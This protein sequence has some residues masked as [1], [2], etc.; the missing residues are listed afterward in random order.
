MKK[1]LLTGAALVAVAAGALAQGSFNLIANGST[2]PNNGLFAD[3]NY[4]A[5]TYGV[6]VYMLNATTGYAPINTTAKTSGLDA[7]AMLGAAGYKLEATFANQSI[8]AANA[9]WMNVGQVNMAD[10]NP[11][12]SSVVVALAA[13]N[14]SAASW[15]AAMAAGG[16]TLR[17]GVIAFPQAT[18]NFNAQPPPTP[19]DLGWNA[20]GQDLVMLPVPEPSTFA[21]VGLGAAALLI[22]RRR[23]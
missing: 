12:G 16:A 1:L 14:S 17:A 11:A 20:V 7:Y 6:E 9:G 19:T 18:A 2:L 10:V 3:G 4:Y 23:K 15:S 21:L 8:T 13:W 5:G 22:F